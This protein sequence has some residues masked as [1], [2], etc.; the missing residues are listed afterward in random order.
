[1]MNQ[2]SGAMGSAPPFANGMA[3]GMQNGMHGHN[4]FTQ[5]AA[6]APL[7]TAAP[8]EQ[9]LRAADSI[10]GGLSN[11]LGR[12]DDGTGPLL[13]RL[14]QIDEL[15]GLGNLF[16]RGRG[17]SRSR[18]SA[19]SKS[20]RTS[21]RSTA[22][23]KKKDTDKKNKTNRKAN[24]KDDDSSSTDTSSSSK[25]KKSRKKKKRHRGDNSESD[26]G[27]REGGRSSFDPYGSAA[28]AAAA[29][30]AAAAA[31]AAATANALAR[32]SRS[33]PAAAVLT[34]KQTMAAACRGL[35]E[36]LGRDRGC[37]R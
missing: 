20:S 26:A 21:R 23:T 27:H 19:R 37:E 32:G 36:S 13:R 4:P 9:P 29:A 15:D 1:M 5:H 6:Q 31:N 18:G 8:Q 25:T 14:R 3:N 24:K 28:G 22:S 7:N 16:R 35:K 34:E 10:L 2:Y 11:L 12:T 17:R 30:A 33:L